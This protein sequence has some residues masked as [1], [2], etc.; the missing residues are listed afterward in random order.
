MSGTDVVEA[1]AGATHRMKRQCIGMGA[2]L[3]GRNHRIS[4]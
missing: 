3:A 4:I 2:Q 1:D